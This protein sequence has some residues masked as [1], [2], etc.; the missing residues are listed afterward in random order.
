MGE[1]PNTRVA[2]RTKDEGIV[3]TCKEDGFG[4]SYS[5]AVRE[6]DWRR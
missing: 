6:L 5:L 2:L 3:W 4:Q 1:R